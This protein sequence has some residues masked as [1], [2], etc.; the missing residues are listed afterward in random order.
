M[1]YGV[2]NTP[3]A[4]SAPVLYVELV[5]IQSAENSS[6]RLFGQYDTPPD[7]SRAQTEDRR[8]KF[9]QSPIFS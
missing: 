4:L 3:F 5:Q 6:F 9:E 8:K 2:I 1:P 7:A